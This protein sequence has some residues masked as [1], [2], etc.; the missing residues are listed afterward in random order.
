M[1]FFP[2]SESPGL[3]LEGLPSFPGGVT[4]GHQV[5]P[6]MRGRISKSP[7]SRRALQPL[8][9][10]RIGSRDECFGTVSHLRSNQPDYRPKYE[11]D[12]GE[13]KTE[14]PNELLLSP[15]ETG[16][17]QMQSEAADDASPVEE[18]PGKQQ[19]SSPTTPA[20]SDNDQDVHHDCQN[21]H[22]RHRC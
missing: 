8:E 5:F 14:H 6:P 10:Q 17:V 19:R 3:R 7:G 21:Y 4:V 13:A 18:K 11:E 22:S 20:A 15:A 1:A 16:E 12:E 9:R 2:G